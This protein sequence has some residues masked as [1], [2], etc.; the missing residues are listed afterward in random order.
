[1]T[2]TLLNIL[3]PK[4]YEQS[5]VE[6]SGSAPK[7]LTFS[8]RRA[9]FEARDRETARLQKDNKLLGKPDALVDKKINE[10]MG[11]QDIEQL[12]EELGIGEEESK[13]GMAE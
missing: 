13:E 5:P 9:A 10:V 8:R 1:M 3:K 12:E 6:L 2:E 11:N 7:A 4:V